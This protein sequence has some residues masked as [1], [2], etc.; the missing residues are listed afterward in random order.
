VQPPVA[1]ARG[2]GAGKLTASP[3][4]ADDTA[5]ASAIDTEL[6]ALVDEVSGSLDF[7]AVQPDA[8]HLE[9][10]AISGG[11]SLPGQLADRLQ[12]ALQVP[13]ERARP[14]AS[15]RVGRLGLDP[16]QLAELEPRSAVPIGLALGA[17]A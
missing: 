12:A 10:V 1:R 17:V 9:R 16:D 5:V 3:G 13:V 8:V 4:P 11:G 2:R 6:G 14:L 7:Y 15:I